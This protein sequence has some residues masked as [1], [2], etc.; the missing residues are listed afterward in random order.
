VGSDKLFHKNKI[1]TAKE[2][3]RRKA[4]KDSYETVWIVC[5]DS[6]SACSYLKKFI[7]HF[8][9]NAANVVVIPS[10]GS[11]PIT[12]VNYAIEI[13]QNTPDIDRIFCIFDRDNHESY[14]RA[15]DKLNRHKPKRKDKSKPQFTIITSTPCF[16]LWLLLHHRY[17]T[18]SYS[19]TGN[20]SAA[21]NLISD[22]R[23]EIPHYTKNASSWF[24]NSNDKLYIAIKHSKKL[25][26]HNQETKSLNP[27]TN[28]HVIVEYLI[29]LKN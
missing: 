24:S 28:F 13:A 23:E 9:L 22:L 25:T 5:E 2:L 26:K 10:P 6:K 19:P 21:D 27:Q 11:A 17:T 18:K 8:R 29:N 16:E 15:I 12:V 14:L 3:V 20:K 4:N 7:Q 1:R